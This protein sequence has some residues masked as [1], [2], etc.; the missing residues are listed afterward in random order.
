[1]YLF[2][3]LPSW[4][5]EGLP[6]ETSPPTKMK[7]SQYPTPTLNTGVIR[8]AYKYFHG[9]SALSKAPKQ[10]TNKLSLIPCWIHQQ[11]RMPS[12]Y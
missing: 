8:S 11:I 5:A 6:L 4:E 1:L 10:I 7:K 3:G 2:S 9:R 12:S